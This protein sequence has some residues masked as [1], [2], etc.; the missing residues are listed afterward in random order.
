MLQRRHLPAA[1]AATGILPSSTLAQ[2]TGGPAHRMQ[3][4]GHGTMSL[5]DCVL[6]CVRSHAMCLET[7]RYC[8]EQTS[9]HIGPG[10]IAL[11]QDCAEMCQLTANSLLRRSPRHA[12]ICNACAE[13]CETC[14]KA[15]ETFP[16]DEQMRRCAVVCRDCAESCRDMARSPI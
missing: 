13:L 6:T 11:L 14:T 16:G 10:H 9:G 2:G 12:V 4:G 7:A 1:L 15:C 3:G 5:R 8:T